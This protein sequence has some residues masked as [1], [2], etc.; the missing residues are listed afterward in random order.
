MKPFDLEKAKAGHPVCTRDGCE[1]RILCFDK[2]SICST[3]IVALYLKDGTE[4]L[5]TY[6]NNGKVYLIKDSSKD[7]CMKPQKREGWINIY[8]DSCGT[9]R[10]SILIHPSKGDAIIERQYISNY[11]DTVKIEW[12]E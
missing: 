10:N 5:E 7:L 2:I 9:Y 8:K 4:Y 6:H 11:I 1:A 3:S 12:E